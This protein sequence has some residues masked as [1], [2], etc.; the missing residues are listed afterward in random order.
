MEKLYTSKAFWKM[1]G[2]R[3]HTPHPTPPV[4]VPGHKLQKPSKECGIFQS[5]GIIN[6]ALITKKA[7]S[8]GGHDPMAPSLNTLL[9]ARM[10][11]LGYLIDP[12]AVV[13]W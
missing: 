3:M 13:R 10:Q 7:E 5:L 4:S 11:Y 12:V 8:K 1:V 9:A 6:F 2:G